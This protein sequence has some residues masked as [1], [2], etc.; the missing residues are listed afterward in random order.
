MLGLF[1][2]ASRR[3]GLSRMIPD[4]TERAESAPGAEKAPRFE[5]KGFDFC[6]LWNGSPREGARRKA[7][8]IPWGAEFSMQTEQIRPFQFFPFDP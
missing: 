6:S 7:P 3:E 5:T 2:R 8:T 4:E 1:F